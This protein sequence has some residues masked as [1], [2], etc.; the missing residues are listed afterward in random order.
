MFPKNQKQSKQNKTQNKTKQGGNLINS[1]PIP[2]GIQ[3]FP[4]WAGMMTECQS[5]IYPCGNVM[6]YATD[7]THEN[8][9]CRGMKL[10]D[11][12]EQSYLTKT[13]LNMKQ[14]IS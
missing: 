2:L 3:K 9:V 14:V 4:K 12:S 13:N 6:P 7:R 5:L 8:V 11:S 10:K 1:L